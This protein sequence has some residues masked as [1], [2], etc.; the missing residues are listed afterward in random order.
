MHAR[1]GA[2]F[3]EPP[4]SNKNRASEDAGMKIFIHTARPIIGRDKN[5]KKIVIDQLLQ[6]KRHTQK[7][8]N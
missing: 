1:A 7:Y 6:P 4:K 2:W 3:G 5:N 8:K